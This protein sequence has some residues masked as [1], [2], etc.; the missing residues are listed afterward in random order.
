VKKNLNRILIGLVITGFFLAH[1]IHVFRLPLL[2]NL[3]A[4]VYDTRLRLT[5]PRTVDPRV[6]I[7]DIDEKSLLEKEK[8]G[9][10]RWPWPAGAAARQA[11]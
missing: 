1:A 11:V 9:E 10:G 7:L 5:M 8:G 2:D 4:I 6:V 3:E